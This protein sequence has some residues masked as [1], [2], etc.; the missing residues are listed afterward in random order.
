[1]DHTARSR[2][3]ASVLTLVVVHGSISLGAQAGSQGYVSLGAGATDI[4]GGVDWIIADGPVGIGGEVGAGW[5]FLAA[6]TGSFH[7]LAGQSG[8]HQPFATLGY[9]GLG[10]SEFSSHGVTVGGGTVYWRWTRV[11]LRFDAFRFLPVVTDN[12]ISAEERSPS[13][14]WGV[15]AGVAFRL[16]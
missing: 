3:R 7:L 12:N 4:N 15:R 8:R 14:Y 16:R 6:V 11:G 13:R 5:A 9:A 2:W 1:M 10:S